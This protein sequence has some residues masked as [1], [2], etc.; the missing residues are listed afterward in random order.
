MQRELVLYILLKMFI[1]DN[2]NDYIYSKK[3]FEGDDQGKDIIYNIT[4]NIFEKYYEF[5]FFI[6]D[7]YFIV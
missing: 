1:E 5:E 7:L 6:N 4:N 3:R 2:N